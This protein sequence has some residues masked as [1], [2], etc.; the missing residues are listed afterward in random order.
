MERK[1]QFSI[2]EFYHLYNRG[3]NKIPIFL[4]DSDKERFIKLLFVC[5]GE[6]PVVFKTIQGL[7]LDKI[8]RGDTLVNIGA[9]CLMPNHLHLLIRE[10]KENGISVFMGKLL[11]AYSMY[12]NK[13]YERTGSLF[14]GE[15]KATHANKDDYLK[16]LFAYIHLN[17][18]KLIDPLWKEKGISDTIKAN[19]FLKTYKY[20]S[21]LDYIGFNRIEFLILN[22]EEFPEYFSDLKEF[23]EYVDYWLKYKIQGLPLE[24]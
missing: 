4:D 6:K 7:P 22:K 8:E 9:Y 1:F 5:N 24:D 21:F 13:K 14:E 20:S 23:N 3:V 2:G 16:Y 19:D 10:K 12:F 11:T 18:I 17:P 15:F